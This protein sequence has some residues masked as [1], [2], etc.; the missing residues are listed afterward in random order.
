M[1]R[2]LVAMHSQLRLGDWPCL[3]IVG[4]ADGDLLRCRSTRAAVG[5]KLLEL[6]FDGAAG[7]RC[8]L[9]QIAGAP[10]IPACHGPVWPP[11]LCTLEDN[12]G[13]GQI[14]SF[15]GAV[16]G[17]TLESEC[18]SLTHAIVRYRQNVG[19]AHAEDE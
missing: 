2:L 16:F 12:I 7:G 15:D 18:E 17:E 1:Y 11:F 4:C 8:S 10:Q 6:F 13:L 5:G 3:I 14:G 19:A 9:N